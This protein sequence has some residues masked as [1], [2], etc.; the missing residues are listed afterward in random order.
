MNQDNNVES[1]QANLKKLRTERETLIQQR[2]GCLRGSNAHKRKTR[3]IH[4]LDK[5]IA[6]LDKCVKRIAQV[7]LRKT[8]LKF[9]STPTVETPTT[10]GD[11]Q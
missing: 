1:L 5:R 6:Y 10:G 3:H 4:N 9:A 2:L 11:V 7:E 8:V